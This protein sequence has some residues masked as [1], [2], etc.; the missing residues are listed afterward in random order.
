MLGQNGCEVGGVRTLVQGD[1]AWL[2]GRAGGAG[3]DSLGPR[4]CGVD[5]RGSIRLCFMPIRCSFGI[6]G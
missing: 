1:E 3:H 5:E 2:A 6:P 4:F